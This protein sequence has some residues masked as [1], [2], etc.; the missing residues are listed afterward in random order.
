MATAAAA[1]ASST[2][3]NAATKRSHFVLEAKKV[4]AAAHTPGFD[5]A[6]LRARTQAEGH[7]RAL[8]AA[9]GRPPFV[10][11]VNVGQVIDRKTQQAAYPELTL[12]GMYNVLEKLR[13]GEALNAKDKLI[14]SQ[15][16]VSVL[17]SL[18]DEIDAAVLAAY[19]WPNLQSALTDYSKADARAAATET[20]L[21]RLV[22]RTPAHHHRN[23]RSPRSPRNPRSPGQHAAGQRANAHRNEAGKTLA[24]SVKW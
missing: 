11:V 15:G 13:S 3:T 14:H 7:A 10:V 16:L 8:P 9:E 24:G 4:R 2:A 5:A 22:A 20:L 18:H 1:P 19:G 21:E 6:L 12:T 17:K 23:P